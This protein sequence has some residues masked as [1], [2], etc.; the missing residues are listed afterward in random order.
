[1][2][3]ARYLAIAAI[4][5]CTACGAEE[6]QS[7]SALVDGTRFAGDNDT[8]VLV[9]LPSGQFTLDAATAGAAGWPPPKTPIE[10]LSI[11]CKGYAPGKTFKLG[12]AD[13]GASSHCYAKFIKESSEPG[14]AADEYLLDKAN[15]TISFE[16]TAAHGKVIEGTFQMRLINSS[17][18]TLTIGDGHFVAEDRQ[19]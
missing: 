7:L 8:I 15:P 11:V 2:V 5:A 13:F 18:R 16:V 1:M 14:K 4:M 17:G 3:L 19:L 12:S 10:R 9:P 6:P